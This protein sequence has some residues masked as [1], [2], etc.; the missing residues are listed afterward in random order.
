[1][2]IAPIR[3]AVTVKAP[4]E[5]AFLLFA[6]DIGKWW[7]RTM[8]IAAAP[9]ADVILEPRAGGRWFERGEDGSETEWGRVAPGMSPHVSLRCS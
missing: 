7:P 9:Q 5:R 3:H 8:S 2:T 1:M 6:R 4:P